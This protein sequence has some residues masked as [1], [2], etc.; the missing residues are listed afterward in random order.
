MADVIKEK[1]FTAGVEEGVL[2][3]NKEENYN[4]LRDE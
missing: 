1:T 4:P 3:S 2:E